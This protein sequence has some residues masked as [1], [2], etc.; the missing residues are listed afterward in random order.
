[1]TKKEKLNDYEGFVEKFKPKKTTDDCY[2]PPAIYEVIRRW[3]DENIISLNGIDVVRPF[4]PGGDYKAFDYPKNCLV[5]DNPPFSILA[6]IRRYYHA[7]GIRYFLFAPTLTFASS[8]RELDA[9]CI[10]TGSH[11]TYE[12]GASIPTSFITNLECH[13]ARIWVAGDLT[14]SLTEAVKLYNRKVKPSKHSYPPNVVSPA[15]LNSLALRGITLRIPAEECHPI[16]ALDSQRESG[17][18]LYGGGWLVSERAA[19]ERAAAER[20]AAERAAAERAA[21]ERAAAE[22]DF[23]WPLSE[24]EKSIIAELSKNKR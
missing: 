3:V 17:K 14:A 7:R 18:S 5:L 21:A 4:W 13:G 10:V 22:P 11:I 1:M 15:L 19:A 23:V 6:A 2:T 16:A 20:A 12:N 24:R 8:A 9:S